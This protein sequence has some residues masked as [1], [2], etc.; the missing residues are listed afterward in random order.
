ME[1]WLSALSQHKPVSTTAFPG[2]HPRPNRGE[3]GGQQCP[4]PGWLPVA[5]ISP[6][7]LDPYNSL[8]Y[9]HLNLVIARLGGASSVGSVAEAVLIAQ[10]FLDLRVDLIDR[11]LLRDFKQ[12][13]SGLL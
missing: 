5:V 6:T 10:L 2:G 1:L 8:L 11:L 12:P 9:C 3:S 13:P 7:A 4:A